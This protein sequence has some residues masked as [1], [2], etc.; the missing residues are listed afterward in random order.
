M[1]DH[2]TRA[3][4][5]TKAKRL[6]GTPAAAEYL[7][8]AVSTLEKARLNGRGPRFVRLGSRAV[9]YDVAD[10]DAWIDR[11]KAESTSAPPVIGA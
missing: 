8:L 1:N 7:A 6:L 9:A 10:L 4:I 3:A 11:Q 5:H 2:N